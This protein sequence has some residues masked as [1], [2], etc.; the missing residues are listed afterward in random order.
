VGCTDIADNT[1]ELMFDLQCGDGDV[2]KESRIRGQ[3]EKAMGHRLL[4]SVS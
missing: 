3:K 4:Y 1:N 2:V